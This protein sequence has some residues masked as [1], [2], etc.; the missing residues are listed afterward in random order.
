MSARD[1]EAVVR[2]VHDAFNARELDRALAHAAEDGEWI[3]VP[4]GETF[5]GPEGYRQYMMGLIY[6]FSDAST[7]ITDVNA[8][9]DFAVVEFV[10]RGTHDGTLRSP[11]GEVPPTGRSTEIR[12][13]EVLRLENGKISRSRTY[14]DLATMMTQL[15]VMPAPEGAAG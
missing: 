10:G 11:A 15:G 14:L 5:H 13:C 7:E 2:E 6:A 1:N 9:E 8:G 4:T 3:V 12:F